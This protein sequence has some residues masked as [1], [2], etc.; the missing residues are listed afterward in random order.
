MPEFR[1]IYEINQIKLI[2]FMPIFCKRR[3]TTFYKSSSQSIAITENCA[4]CVIQHTKI[5]QLQ[6]TATAECARYNY[7]KFETG[8]AILIYRIAGNFEDN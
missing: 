4:R 1:Q 3:H 6:L 7:F 5:C 2:K 8:L